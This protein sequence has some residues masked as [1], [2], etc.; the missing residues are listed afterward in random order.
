MIGVDNY[1][2]GYVLLE[3]RIDENKDVSLRLWTNQ[4]SLD[5]TKLK[6]NR[7]GVGD[8]VLKLQMFFTYP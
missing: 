3:I 2:V 4:N 6:K 1:Y 7:S 8:G 5:A